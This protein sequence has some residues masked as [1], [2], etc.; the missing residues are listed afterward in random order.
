[1]TVTVKIFIVKSWISLMLRVTGTV[2]TSEN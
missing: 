1:M 2:P